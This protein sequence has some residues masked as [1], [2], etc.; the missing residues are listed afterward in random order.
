MMQ[1]LEGLRFDGALDFPIVQIHPRAQ[2]HFGRFE[3]PSYKTLL[4]AASLLLLCGCPSGPPKPQTNKVAHPFRGQ[5]VELVVPASLQLQALWQVALDEW[6]AE[7]GATVRWSEYSGA[8]DESLEKK[9]SAPPAAG[10]RIVLF[11]LRKLSELDKQLAPVETAASAGLDL[12]DIFKGLRD[13]VVS[14]DRSVIAIPISAPVLLCYYRADLLRA[15]GLK[16]PETW[17]DYQTLLDAL[18]RWAPG[19]TAVEPLGPGHRATLFFA[20]S[21]AFVKHPENYSVWFDLDSGKPQL[22]T[23]GFQEAIEVSSRAWKKM[24]ASIADLSP[25]DCRN[26]VLAG[27][28]AMAI[29]VEPVSSTNSDET[30]RTASIEIGICRL[31]GSRRVYNSNSRRWDVQ[32]QSAIHAP[33]LCGFDG[34]TIGVSLPNASSKASVAWHLLSTL[35]GEQFESNWA[36]LPKSPCRESQTGT[37][38]SWNESGL[39]IEESGRAIDATAL[40]LRDNQLVADLPLPDAAEFRAVTEET[41]GKLLKAELDPAT[42]IR[43]LHAEFEQ[44]VSRIG[45]DM[46]RADYRRGLGL[47]ALEATS[48]APKAL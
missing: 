18:D 31:P 29:G 3:K 45:A 22:D 19:L 25:A 44:I 7:T 39:T 46:I 5:D 38:S 40:M 1:R 34:M 36:S 48:P 41:I 15:A 11:P 9:L 8:G 24:P 14:R 2:S 13:R 32:P 26:Q 33:A 20:R 42:T 17:D 21:L 23:A 10:G 16:P 6:M 43:Q 30:P 27:K 12:K 37:A 35:T 47:P 4:I 28:A